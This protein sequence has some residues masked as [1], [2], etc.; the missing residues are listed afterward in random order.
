[1]ESFWMPETL[2]AST[3]LLYRSDGGDR[4]NRSNGHNRS[5]GSDWPDRSNWGN[6]TD[7]PDGPNRSGGRSNRPNWPHG[8]DCSVNICTT[9]KLP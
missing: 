1:M 2:P 4:C 8:R 9:R 5:N 6:R 7:R 3:V